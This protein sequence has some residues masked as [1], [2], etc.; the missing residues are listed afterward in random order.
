MGSVVLVT[1]VSR[2]FGGRFAR[3]IAET[4]GVALAL[5]PGMRRGVRMARAVYAQVLDRVEGNGYDVLG[6]N[7]ELSGVEVLLP[8][9]SFRAAVRH[10]RQ[11][12]RF[13]G[14][15]QDDSGRGPLGE[16][17]PRCLWTGDARQPDIHQNQVGGE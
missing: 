7:R 4:A 1:G 2:D 11:V 5:A 17:L 3:L 13:V 9:E 8:H 12:D 16:D 14:R 15:Q 6:A 10:V